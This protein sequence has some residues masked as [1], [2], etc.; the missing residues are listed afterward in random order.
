MNAVTLPRDL[1][2]W[3]TSEVSAGRA[4]DA[5][6]VVAK[7]LRGYRY[8]IEALRKS[9]DD[10][11]AGADRDGWLSNDEVFDELEALYPDAD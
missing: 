7:A 5:D 2:E 9:L 10:A 1:D 3:I 6:A 4:A 11:V 8:Q